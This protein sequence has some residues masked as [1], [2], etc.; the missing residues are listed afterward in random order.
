MK[1]ENSRPA[2]IEIIEELR[3][4]EGNERAII[5]TTCGY[6]EL[7]V[8][9]LIVEHCKNQSRIKQD[10]RSYPYSSRLV[11]LNELG[12]I[13]DSLFKALDRFR[14]LRNRAAHYAI[15]KVTGDDKKNFL[16]IKGQ[17]PDLGKHCICLL[18]TSPSP[19]D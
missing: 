9:A 17:E 3:R 14:D 13:D 1:K 8:E 19:R 18:Y 6:C 5:L 16:T 7:L 12:I 4:V 10:S 15:L 2:F 11:I